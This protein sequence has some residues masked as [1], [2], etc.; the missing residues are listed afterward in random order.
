MVVYNSITRRLRCMFRYDTVN[1][2]EASAQALY[3]S[4][5]MIQHQT[6]QFL[7]NSVELSN[8]GEVPRRLSIKTQ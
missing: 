3:M 5:L 7:P 6:F 1:S 8:V 4:E 2:L